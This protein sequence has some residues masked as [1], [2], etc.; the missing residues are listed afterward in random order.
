MEKIEF[1]TGAV[2]TVFTKPL[3]MAAGAG[4]ITR[5]SIALPDPTRYLLRGTIAASGGEAALPPVTAESATVS[6]NIMLLAP[7]VALELPVASIATVSVD[8]DGTVT[9]QSNATALYVVLT[10][11]SAGRFGENAFMLLPST[12]KKVPFITWGPHF[13]VAA[14][15]QTLRVE[16]LQEHCFH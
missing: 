7:P 13:D 5:F 1:A 4:V 10:T 9:L 8:A 6:A 2:T 14:F 12:P 15:K 3:K 16:H 11:Q